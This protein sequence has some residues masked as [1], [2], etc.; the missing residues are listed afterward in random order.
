MYKTFCKKKK[1]VRKSSLRNIIQFLSSQLC[2]QE[3]NFLLL[4]LDL[5]CEDLLRFQQVVSE[6][7]L[8]MASNGNMLQPNFQGLV[9]RNLINEI[10]N[11][12]NQ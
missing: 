1:K 6:L 12:S 2:K 9:G 4:F 8:D 11:I 7:Q 5:Y 3:N 10:H